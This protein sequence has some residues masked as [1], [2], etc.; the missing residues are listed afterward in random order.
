MIKNYGIGRKFYKVFVC[1]LS[2]LLLNVLILP[3][4]NT[5]G[6]AEDSPVAEPEEFFSILSDGIEVLNYFEA[7]GTSTNDH[8]T[9]VGVYIAANEEIHLILDND[10]NTANQT[11][12]I[13]RCSMVK[14]LAMDYH[15]P[16][17]NLI[18]MRQV[19][20]SACLFGQHH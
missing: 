10:K 16:I 11:G 12:S 19:Q 14:L 17:M 2:I 1:L 8:Y 5:V 13:I 7:Y 9:V 3:I 20:Q 15:L 4:H 6:A 18:G